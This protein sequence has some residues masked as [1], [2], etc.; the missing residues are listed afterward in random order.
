M[1]LPRAHQTWAR[2][3]NETHN[4]YN[5]TNLFPKGIYIHIHIYYNI[6]Y[7]YYIYIYKQQRT[8]YFPLDR[9]TM[10]H[11]FWHRSRVLSKAG[12]DLLEGT[13]NQ[14]RNTSD[15]CR[16]Y[17]H[18]FGHIWMSL[19]SDMDDMA[20]SKAKCPQGGIKGH[21]SFSESFSAS[22]L[23]GRVHPSS[24]FLN[25]ITSRDLLLAGSAQQGPFNLPWVGPHVRYVRVLK[26]IQT[27][28]C[29]FVWKIG[30]IPNYSHLI[31]IMI[32]NHWV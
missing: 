3:I 1:R 31:R 16:S 27:T 20:K 22:R 26:E 24:T 5:I 10:G 4:G 17:F 15:P 9:L 18:Y 30:Y 23:V 14:R 13:P 29:G 6:I 2:T 8:R 32:I 19:K 25:Q 28:P 21:N 12:L 11:T 7:I